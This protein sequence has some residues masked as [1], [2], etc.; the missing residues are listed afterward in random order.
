MSCLEKHLR[1][2]CILSRNLLDIHSVSCI[3]KLQFSGLSPYP[4]IS[5]CHHTWKISREATLYIIFSLI[6]ACL[7]SDFFFLNQQWCKKESS[8]IPVWGVTLEMDPKDIRHKYFQRQHW[9]N[10]GL[11]KE[12]WEYRT[13]SG[14]RSFS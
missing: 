4:Y 3:F 14:F 11:Q 6:S 1:Q 8:K 2:A 10:E 7:N 5:H 13:C 12:K 9:V